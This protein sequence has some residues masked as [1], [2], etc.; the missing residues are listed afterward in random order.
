MTSSYFSCLVFLLLAGLTISGWAIAPMF[1][2]EM[3][4][5]IA[6][7]Y[8]FSTEN[9]WVFGAMYFYQIFGISVSACFTVATDTF[10]SAIILQANGQVQRLG[11]QLTKVF[12]AFNLSL[13]H[14][15]LIAHIQIGHESSSSSD[16]GV[17]MNLIGGQPRRVAKLLSQ[18]QQQQQS[19]S[20]RKATRTL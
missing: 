20:K 3:R 11:I 18:Q 12:Y 5:P 17:Q 7:W 10:T 2:D 14:Y 8:P 16:D 4:L 15:S 9:R 6:A 13:F 19:T 1:Q